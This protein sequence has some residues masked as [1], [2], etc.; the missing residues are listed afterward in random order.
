M[1]HCRANRQATVVANRA[2][3]RFI[4]VAHSSAIG[5]DVHLDLLVC[6]Y[7]YHQD[8][9]IITGDFYKTELTR[10]ASVEFRC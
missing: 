3:Q 9:Q 6:A 1:S 2:S 5:V 10:Y 4:N 7:Q 8:N